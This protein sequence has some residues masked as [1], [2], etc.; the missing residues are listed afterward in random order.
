MLLKAP[1]SPEFLNLLVWILCSSRPPAQLPGSSLSSS[2]SHSQ[3]AASL[4]PQASSSPAAAPSFSLS[5]SSSSSLLLST[6]TTTQPQGPLPNCSSY[7][8]QPQTTSEDSTPQSNP[9]RIELHDAESTLK[10]ATR[11]FNS[12][13]VSQLLPGL[14]DYHLTASVSST[15]NCNTHCHTHTHIHYIFAMSCPLVRTYPFPYIF[16]HI[17]FIGNK[18]AVSSENGFYARGLQGR[19]YIAQSSEWTHV[20]YTPGH[21]RTVTYGNALWLAYGSRYICYIKIRWSLVLHTFTGYH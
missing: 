1:L 18:Q 3:A 10:G 9:A 13:L 6:T 20:Y 16:E 8:L 21:T 7:K 14:L 4:D 17:I 12:S 15:V 19:I 5:S 11:V 2:P